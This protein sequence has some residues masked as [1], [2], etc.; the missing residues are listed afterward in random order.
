MRLSDLKQPRLTESRIRIRHHRR[1][2][3]ERVFSAMVY[4]LKHRDDEAAAAALSPVLKALDE[5]ERDRR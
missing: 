4:C 3:Y 2:P 5:E 1:S